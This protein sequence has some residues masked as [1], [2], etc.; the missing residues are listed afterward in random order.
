MKHFLAVCILTAFILSGVSAIETIAVSVKP[1]PASLGTAS[2]GFN[3]FLQSSIDYAN[4]KYAAHIRI[5]RDDTAGAGYFLRIEP[6]DS[7]GELFIN[8]II[9]QKKTGKK[10]PGRAFSGTPDP[11]NARYLAGTIFHQW[12]SFHD[13]FQDG[14]T[15]APLFVDEIPVEKLDFGYDLPQ[16]MCIRE[17]GNIIFGMYGSI[18]EYCPNLEFLF[19]YGAD[20]QKKGIKDFGARVYL[21]PSE[22]LYSRP[23]TGSGLFRFIQ[24]Y[25]KTQQFSIRQGLLGTAGEFAFFA[26]GSFAVVDMT[27]SEVFHYHD[28][29]SSKIELK[30]SSLSYT[31]GVYPD[32]SGNIMVYDTVQQRLKVLSPQDVAIDSVQLVSPPESYLNIFDAGVFPDGTIVVFSASGKLM[33]FD[34]QGLLLWNIEAFPGPLHSALPRAASL[35]LDPYRGLIYLIDLAERKIIRLLDQ[36]YLRRNDIDP[37]YFAEINSLQVRTENTA[38]LKPVYSGLADIY[39]KTGN[40]IMSACY[41]ERALDEDPFDDQLKQRYNMAQADILKSRAAPLHSKTLSVLNTLGPEN[42]RAGYMELLRLYEQILQLVPGDS[43]TRDLKQSVQDRFLQESAAPGQGKSAPLISIDEFRMNDLYPSLMSIYAGKPVGYLTIKN[44]GKER[45][46]RIQLRLMIPR[47]MD[48]PWTLDVAKPLESGDNLSADLHALFNSE[49]LA[50]QEII[51]AAAEITVLYSTG[52]TEQEISKFA[53]FTL[54]RNTSLSW[55]DSAKLLSFITPNENIVRDFAL[56]VLG[57][58]KLPAPPGIS[59]KMAH[60]AALLEAVGLQD[61]SYIEDPDG[62]I[63]KTLGSATVID[64]VRFPRTTLQIRSGD[65]DDT[66]ALLCSLFEAAGIETAVMTSPGH[67]FLAFNSEEPVENRWMYESNDLAAV[68]FGGTLWIPLESTVTQ[69]G[70]FVAWQSASTILKSE[71]QI[72]FIPVKSRREDYPAIPLRQS[73]VEIVIPAADKT[74]K[75]LMASLAAMTDVLYGQG[76]AYLQSTLSSVAGRKKIKLQNQLAILHGRFGQS[77]KALELLFEILRQ[78]NEYMA[79]YL[80]I[81]NIYTEQKLYEKAADI[82]QTGLKKRP[83]SALLNLALARCSL[84]MNKKQDALEYFRVVEDL[85]SELAERYAWLFSGNDTRAG[86]ETVIVPF[87]DAGE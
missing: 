53:G 11:D 62:G 14:T 26:D 31:G 67:V 38:A 78:D 21:T 69:E 68:T 57:N 75:A 55:D 72:E 34:R 61:I 7:N 5:G 23:L 49:F 86:T 79:A 74:D 9:E 10:S 43:E 17:N 16:T 30:N 65:C 46:N 35:A 3:A 44:T 24:G 1:P 37:G 54:F 33:A 48:V 18:R 25:P 12:A 60:A 83:D 20:L 51:P 8:I 59:I 29:K 66:T 19:S 84:A 15:A 70:F 77:V 45:I 50:N 87:W 63:A 52:E 36:S 13:Y 2:T 64:T 85:S 47:Y 40:R 22:V 82:L 39:R 73:S 41:L 80:N 27:K 42:A 71:K 56:S 76:K 58:S 28:N 32:F 6:L 81:A 4:S